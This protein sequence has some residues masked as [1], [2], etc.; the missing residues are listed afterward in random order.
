MKRLSAIEKKLS[1][2]TAMLPIPSTYADHTRLAPSQSDHE[3]PVPGRALNEVTVKDIGDPKPPQMSERLVKSMDAAHSSKANKV[4]AAQKLKSRDICITTYSHETRT[5][6]GKKEGWTQVIA[7]QTKVR[8]Q[9]FTVM[10]HSVQT[11]RIDT[12][13]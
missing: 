10:A 2:L 1:A 7:G 13:N 11:N 6:L 5:L 3:K 4:L 9:Q 12:K 8:G